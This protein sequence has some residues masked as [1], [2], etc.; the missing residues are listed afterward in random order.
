MAARG[1]ARRLARSNQ[2]ATAIEY[3]L[4]ALFL[5]LGIV[6]ILVSTRSSLQGNF[7]RVATDVSS[8]VDGQTKV[9][10]PLSQRAVLPATSSTRYPFWTGKALVS[11]A[12]TADTPTGKS[13]T[14]TYAD[15]VSAV[16]AQTFDANGALTGETVTVNPS[17]FAGRL[18]DSTAFTYDAA[19]NQ[20]AMNYT[21]R[22]AS[23]VVRQATYSTAAT[24]WAEYV[25]L[26]NTSGGVTSAG[27]YSNTIQ[28]VLD[29]GRG[30]EIY[31]RALAQGL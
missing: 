18:Y 21:D 26:Y 30:D 11:T 12:V 20:I 1:F 23:G 13:I 4:L 9:V 10:Y 16:Y 27:Y 29:Y 2:G 19:G 3:S 24:G 25:T 5:G 6:A 31:F 14:F 17:N 8:G 7:S 22:Y 15:G 28:S